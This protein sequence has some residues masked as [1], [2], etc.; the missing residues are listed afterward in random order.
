MTLPANSE[1]QPDYIFEVSWEVC[2]KVGGIYTVLASKS[3]TLEREWQERLILIGP[4]IWKGEGSHP[5]FI[6]DHTLF[7]RWRIHAENEGLKIKIG[8][9]NIPGTPVVALVDFTPF[10][11]HK[12]EIFSDLWVTYQLDS[13]TGGWDYI[14]PAIFGY[15]AGKVI[16]CFYRFHINYTDKVIA[17]F[18][19]W[20]TGTGVLYLETFTPQIATV[21]TA[22]ATVLG[23]TIAGTGNALYGNLEKYI[24]EQ[25]AKEF[26]VTAKH[27]LEKISAANADCFTTVSEVTALECARFLGKKPDLITPNGFDNSIVPLEPA[28]GI[29]RAQ[30]RK[31]ILKVAKA[32][33][34]QNLPDDSLLVIKSGRYEF[35]NKGIDVFIDSL[36]NINN[37]KPLNKTII[38]MIFVPGHHTG[39]RVELLERMDH[40][41][42]ATPL[43][44]EWLTHNLQG[45][46]TDPIL[47][48]IKQ[49]ELNN[50]LQDKVKIL[51]VPTYMNGND[52]IFNLSYYDLL[53][54][55]DL[56]VF[57]SYYEPWGYTPLES[58]AFHI[59]AITT[60]VSGF[61]KALRDINIQPDKGVY[62]IDR[63]D[64]NEADVAEA[65][66]SVIYKFSLKTAAEV[67]EQRSTASDISKLF[68]WERQIEQYMNAYMLALKK[69]SQ[70]ES[71]Y[72]KK[73]QAEP[74]ALPEKTESKPYWR[75]MTIRT[76]LPASLKVLQ[77]L[78]MNLWWGWNDEAVELFEH[79]DKELWQAS[80]QNPLIFLR[81][82]SYQAIKKLQGDQSFIQKATSVKTSM[83]EYLGKPA[84]GPTIAYFSMEYGLHNTIKLYSGGLGILAGDFLKEAS[85]QNINLIGVGLLYKKGYSKQYLSVSGEQVPEAEDL[86]FS[87]IPLQPVID[88]EGKQIKVSVPFPSRRVNAQ[89]WKLAIGRTTLYLLDCFVTENSIEDRKIT[90]QLYDNDEEK[91]LQQEIILGI[92]G[93]QLFDVLQISP[94]IYHCNDGHAAFIGLGRLADLILKD[95]LSFDEALE[96]VRAS[97]LF[98]T[99]TSM[100]AAIDSFSEAILRPYFGH[101]AQHFNIS[102]ERL[103]SLGKV[104]EVDREEKFSMAYL[105]CRLSQEINAVSKI[106]KTVSC[107]LFNILWKDYQP[108][109]LNISYVTNGVHYDTWTAKEWKQLHKNA[110]GE[111][112]TGQAYGLKMLEVD[113]DT[114]WEI[115]KKLKKNLLNAIKARLSSDMILHHENPGKMENALSVLNDNAFIIGFARRIT[116]YKRP[117]L[118]F[119]EPEQLA[120]IL[121][122]PARPVLLLISGKAHP[123]D[124]EGLVLLKRIVQ[125]KE[126]EVFKHKII[127]LEDYDIN[128][129]KL[130]TQGVDLWLNTPNRRT[131]A[132]G[133]SGMKAILNGV[134]NLSVLDGWWAEA[135][136]KDAGWA[137]PA[138][139][140]YEDAQFQNE[141]DAAYI[142]QMLENEIIP[143]YFERKDNDIPEGW[144][145]Y[146]KNAISIAPTYTMTRVLAD[147]RNIYSKLDARTK[148]IK[149]ENYLLA[150]KITEWKKNI[151][152]QWMQIDVL[153]VKDPNTNDTPL[154][155]PFKIEIVLD[156]G[157][158]SVSNIGLEVVMRVPDKKEEIPTVSKEFTIV[159][160][161]RSRV[162]YEC[163]LPE[164]QSG[165]YEY[166]FRIF[167]KK[168][169]LPNRQD[170]GLV[171]WI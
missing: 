168:P 97:T 164:L 115:R 37:T 73:P 96:V 13:L 159:A 138:E 70:R 99:H 90:S 108:D 102:W 4:D 11:V 124:Q 140:A 1:L 126:Q 74:I 72:R 50:G 80:H 109:E 169:E 137:L 127:F 17:Q 24:P 111:Y 117:E 141:L 136:T 107:Q 87:H 9:W 118:I 40:I 46:D 6:E 125:L 49:N 7:P 48:R 58:L 57:P 154:K 135:Y 36:A 23:R 100:P 19:E 61:G 25:A 10:F 45:A 98:T 162:S 44:K 55:F 60:S 139:P 14:E 171:T 15:A 128:L 88:A 84:S 130:L 75:Q 148:K 26:N 69:S 119:T 85:D 103:M 170:M 104:N 21:I 161:D 59:P 52:G 43:E 93:I 35:H 105:A 27:S 120:K 77:D 86:D 156:I 22:H 33:L 101:L 54:G 94:D 64:N 67:N 163:L 16:E 122:N 71:L 83:D 147:Y 32:L 144:L 79:I 112:N 121:N 89:I 134:V 65:V 39:P 132:S 81:S 157:L 18:H 151:R 116:A 158:L 3:Q 42:Y 31:V 51:F 166:S 146:I 114:I 62:I 150:K 41:N 91:R 95:H 165:N 78:S 82:L 28:F 145:K 131:E 133:T 149:A 68:E 5:E 106:H 113:N 56:A 110:W 47:N 142:Y 29:K 8:R 34:N 20:M 12:N 63:N 2:N 160:I 38:A 152:Q 66:A 167:P 143:L 30:A 123:S 129:A 155:A 53:I 153:S 76:E 92:G